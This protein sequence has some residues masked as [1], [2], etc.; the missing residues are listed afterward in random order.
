MFGKKKKIMN[1]PVRDR[2]DK[3]PSLPPGKKKTSL[4][5]IT[6]VEITRSRPDIVETRKT[7][8][9]SITVKNF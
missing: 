1:F 3:P 7:L 2:G 4:G 5:V 8:Y 9:S 6:I